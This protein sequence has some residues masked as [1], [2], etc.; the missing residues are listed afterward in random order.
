M[1]DFI[2]FLYNISAIEKKIHTEIAD[3][4]YSNDPG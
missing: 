4:S 2:I 3:K 1:T